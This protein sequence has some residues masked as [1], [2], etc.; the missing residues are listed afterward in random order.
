MLWYITNDMGH[1]I[2]ACLLI[3]GIVYL[4]RGCIKFK[5][6]VEALKNETDPK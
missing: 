5:K 2:L 4:I 6:W 1:M 3:A